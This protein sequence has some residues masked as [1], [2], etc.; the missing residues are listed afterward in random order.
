MIKPRIWNGKSH[1]VRAIVKIASQWS[2]VGVPSTDQ[3]IYGWEV[4][5]LCTWIP[6]IQSPTDGVEDLFLGD[7][8]FSVAKTS[9]DFVEEMEI[10]A[11]GGDDENHIETSVEL[12]AVDDEM[13]MEESEIPTTET[14]ESSSTLE[15]SGLCKALLLQAIPDSKATSTSAILSEELL[16]YRA[17]ALQGIA[18]LLK[19]LI[20]ESD[21]VESEKE[22]KKIFTIVARPALSIIDS[23]KIM[24]IETKSNQPPL[25]IAR[26]I[27]AF[28]ASMWP[29]IDLEDKAAEILSVFKTAGGTKQAAWTVRESAAL[30]SSLLALRCSES[31]LRNHK[32]LSTF[33]SCTEQALKDRKFWKVRFAGL[34]ILKSLV[35]RAGDSAL[36]NVVGSK[37]ACPE[38]RSRQLILEALLPHK[39][40]A[41]SLARSCLTDSES[42]I[43]AISTEICGAISWWP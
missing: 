21:P 39:E 36:H 24:A 42:T 19:S 35:G 43:T 14:T 26:A 38:S 27:D 20:Q 2:I 37:K 8:W 28:A 34:K 4:E 9:P 22:I 5:G 15:F 10:E 3:R 18:D 11:T 29:G 16:P 1:V 12:S 40:Q 17:A 31:V 33:L 23:E 25:V 32:C 7:N 13:E 30:A 41:L 6:V